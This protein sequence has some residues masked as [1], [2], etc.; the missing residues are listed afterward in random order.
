M[1]QGPFENL[2]RLGG[3]RA[4]AARDERLAVIRQP[5][6]AF[7]EKMQGAIVGLDRIVDAAGALAGIIDTT[8]PATPASVTATGGANQVRL[9]WQTSTAEDIAGYQVYAVDADGTTQ[10]APIALPTTPISYRSTIDT[11]KF[12]TR[13]AIA[14]GILRRA[15]PR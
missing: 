14:I 5:G 12:A 13:A 6:C 10:P 1:L 9:S 2:A 15:S 11:T 8:A 4:I 3:D 7:A